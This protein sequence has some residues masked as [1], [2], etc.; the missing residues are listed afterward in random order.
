MHAYG[1][2]EGVPDI[3]QGLVS[4]DADEREIAL[5]GL[6]GAVHHQGD[7]YDS[8]V[9]CLPFLFDVVAD[10]TVAGRGAV[11]ELFVSMGES[12][13]G[14]LRAYGDDD[15]DRAVPYRQAEA[16]IRSRAD[17]FVAWLA[18][19]DPQVRSAAAAALVYFTAQP[20][21]VLRLFEQRLAV[22]PVVES[23]IAVITAEA[24]IAVHTPEVGEQVAEWLLEVVG[25]GC[26]PRHPAGSARSSG[27]LGA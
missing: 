5:D 24:D 18:D 17:E 1:S 20:I 2:A 8:T 12:T 7:I 25:G 27:P 21:E 10:A 16:L 26:R 19:D 14:S 9:A 4:E 13:A 23:R 6:H 11:A 3:L 22:E 15:A